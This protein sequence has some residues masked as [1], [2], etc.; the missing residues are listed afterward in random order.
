MMSDPPC[1]LC[2]QVQTLWLTL[3]LRLKNTLSCG[4]EVF[5]VDPHTTLT[6]GH[7]TSLGTDGLDVGTRKVVLLV[8]ELVKID[9]LVERHF[10]G[11]ES[12]DLLL[13]SFCI[14]ISICIMG[15]VD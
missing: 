4:A 6:E 11:V 9:I 14:M 15:S 12:E 7:E 1:F 3:S 8:D 5:H 10:G 2:L 13:G